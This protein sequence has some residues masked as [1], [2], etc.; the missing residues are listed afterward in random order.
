[1]QEILTYFQS[2]FTL[3]DGDWWIHIIAIA[4]TFLVTQ[5][6]KLPIK[7]FGTDKLAEKV[8]KNPTDENLR[9]LRHKFNTVF[10]FFPFGAGLLVNFLI[11]TISKKYAFSYEIGLMWGG[12]SATV[13]ET[14][15]RLIRRK[16]E[17]GTKETM[18]D[19]GAE[20]FIDIAK[21]FAEAKND[22]EKAQEEFKKLVEN[23][24][25]SKSK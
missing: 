15:A 11:S 10:I 2:I 12:A 9:I 16:K 24:K 25:N 14:I 4:A 3:Q 21:D 1:M 18:L 19:D 8:I 6:I 7:K 23:A 5:G 17:E 13:Y 20:E 22:V